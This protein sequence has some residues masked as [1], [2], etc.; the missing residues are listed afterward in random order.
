M[1]FLIRSAFT[2][3]VLVQR[4]LRCNL[5]H[6]GVPDAELVA[7]QSALFVEPVVLCRESHPSIDAIGGPGACV[8]DRVVGQGDRMEYGRFNAVLPALGKMN[9]RW[10][11][12]GEHGG[13]RKEILES[14]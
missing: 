3:G 5:C 1:P 8:D 14:S 13:L 10:L 7:K 9:P 4:T 12:I 2:I 6:T 11:R